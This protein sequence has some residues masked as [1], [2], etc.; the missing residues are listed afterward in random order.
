[1]NNAVI[2]MRTV[3]EE[4][5]VVWPGAIVNH[6]S[7]VGKNTFVS[8]NATI[9]GFVNVGGH[10]FI[11]AGSVIVDR[12]NVPENSFIKAGEF[13]SENGSDIKAMKKVAII[14]SNYIPWK[15]YFDIINDVDI[16]VFY[17]D[18][19]YT[20]RDWRNRNRIKTDK[21][22]KWLSIPVGS[23]TKRLIYEV[24]IRNTQWQRDH[25]ET[26]K[27]FY[28]KANYFK[29]YKDF[30]EYVYME[31]TWHNLSELNHYLI[32]NISKF[33]GCNTQ[34]VD[35][36]TIQSSGKKQEKLLSILDSLKATT[37][38]SGP[39]AKAYIQEEDFKKRG[40][41]LIYK[42]YSGYPEYPQFY[43]PFRHDVTILDLLFHTGPDAP[44]YIWGWRENEKNSF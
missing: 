12:R 38:I 22:L 5:V 39:A 18:V 30:F 41:Q 14:Q 20:T 13:L 27:L 28:S 10:S 21:G 2:D 36:R 11:G 7:I 35:S 25:W 42:D 3:L 37:Y 44:Y 43:P 19:Q 16:F 26:I 29:L 1:M 23:D 9:C 4:L 33:L 32:K 40:I 15:G 8:P 34:F 31:N 17:D 6:D 24:Q